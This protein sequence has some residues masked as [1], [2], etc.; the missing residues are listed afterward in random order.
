[1]EEINPETRICR[2]PLCEDSEKPI[3]D[4]S[5]KAS[6]CKKCN[7]HKIKE[8]YKKNDRAY[9]KFKNEIKENS[10]CAECGITDIRVLEFDHHKGIK[11][12]NICKSFSREKIKSELE[13]TQVL[14]TWCHRLKTRKAFDRQIEETNKSFT[15]TER[16]TSTE[17]GRR[18]I[19]AICKGQL[20]FISLFP[21]TKKTYCNVCLSYR[22][23]LIREKNRSFLRDLKL[24][25][26]ECVICKKEVMVD[27]VSCFDYDHVDRDNKKTTLSIL[28]RLNSDKSK[29]MIEESKKCRLLCCNCHKIHTAHQLNYKMTETIENPDT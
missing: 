2:G 29:E 26:K 3:A 4:F 16:P 22:A 20:Q 28:S 27:N 1:M 23:Y 24:T 5:P 13:F 17:D 25:A 15:I 18:C 19:G 8:H 11:N 9:R 10:K 6:I 12:I 14:C 21:K 7:C